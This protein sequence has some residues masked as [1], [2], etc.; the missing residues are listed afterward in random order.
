MRIMKTFDV[1]VTIAERELHV[2]FQAEDQDSAGV[3]AR[4]MFQGC[5]V[6]SPQRRIRIWVLA[7]WSLIVGAVVAGGA[8]TWHSSATVVKLLDLEKYNKRLE[9]IEK[10][11]LAMSATAQRATDA[12]NAATESARQAE[13]AAKETNALAAR[14]LA[15]NANGRISNIL[16]EL[17]RH[18]S[19]ETLDF[20][21]RARAKL[22]LEPETIT[23]KNGDRSISVTKNGIILRYESG[24][25]VELFKEGIHLSGNIYIDGGPGLFIDN[26]PVLHL[27]DIQQKIK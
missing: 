17:E 13:K 7:I 12:A 19:A 4:K 5:T 27:I 21:A 2:R 23:L 22:I 6:G 1:P 8:G 18:S 9:D 16:D 11:L 10:Q 24:P 20:V 26:K 3:L 14:L 15:F 25:Y